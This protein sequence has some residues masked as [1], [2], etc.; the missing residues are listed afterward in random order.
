MVEWLGSHSMMIGFEQV[1]RAFRVREV[2]IGEPVRKMSRQITA[3][4]VTL[5]NNTSLEQTMQVSYQEQKAKLHST[6]VSSGLSFSEKTKLKANI[7]FAD[8]RKAELSLQISNAGEWTTYDTSTSTVTETF[9]FPVK[10]PPRKTVLAQIL[11]EKSECD[12][13][14]SY[15][16]EDGT[17]EVQMLHFDCAGD[18]TFRIDETD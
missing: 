14:V 9:T 13:P 5:P 1:R 11:I 3:K 6:K 12:L 18:V 17:V 7:P 15:H 4:T 2:S 10:V 16:L 8:S